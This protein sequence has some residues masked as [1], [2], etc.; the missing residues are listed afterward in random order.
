M[1][2]VAT[3]PKNHL[4][5]CEHIG[6]KPDQNVIPA[7][8]PHPRGPDGNLRFVLAY[9]FPDPFTTAPA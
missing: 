9:D 7:P 6:M 8:A 3:A 1:A 2:T 4:N 5:E